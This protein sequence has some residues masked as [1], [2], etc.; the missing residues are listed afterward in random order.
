MLGDD[1]IW[2]PMRGSP[3]ESTRT[4]DVEWSASTQGT[5]LGAM[6]GVPGYAGMRAS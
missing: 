6:D 4:S 2:Q 5:A 1:V 3:A